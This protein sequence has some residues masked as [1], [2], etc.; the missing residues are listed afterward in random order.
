METMRPAK[1]KSDN[2]VTFGFSTLLAS[3]SISASTNDE[4]KGKL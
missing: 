2:G 1:S 4:P 3:H